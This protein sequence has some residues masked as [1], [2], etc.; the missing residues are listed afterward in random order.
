MLMQ[1][2][3][4]EWYFHSFLLNWKYKR[5]LQIKLDFPKNLDMSEVS[6]IYN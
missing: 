5:E 4:P 1:I 2:D 3:L 6:E